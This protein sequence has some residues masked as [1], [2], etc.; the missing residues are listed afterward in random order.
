MLPMRV[1]TPSRNRLPGFTLLEIILTTVLF[2]T[3]F[4]ALSQLLSTGIF[5]TSDSENIL[6]A[7]NL[8]REKVEEIKRTTYASVSNEA[9]ASVSGFSGYSRE[10]AVTTPVTNLKQ[11]TVTVYWN[12]KS[13]EISKNWVTYVA[14]TV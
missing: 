5:V 11:V 3:G 1:Q 9:K 6:V 13:S 7:T 8:A 12:S 14:N 2:T 10:V 4:I